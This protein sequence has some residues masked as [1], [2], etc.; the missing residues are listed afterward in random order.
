MVAADI[1]LKVGMDVEKPEVYPVPKYPGRNDNLVFHKL[2]RSEAVIFIMTDPSVLLDEDTLR[3]TE[4]AI[5]S[6]KTLYAIV[7]EGVSFHH[8]SAPNVK[9]IT[10]RP[11]DMRDLINK[12]YGEIS[13]IRQRREN[14]NLVLV[15]TMI[16]IIL[17][18]LITLY[19]I[20]QE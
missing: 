2:G 10:Y 9:V 13:R 8:S 18:A 1:A 19:A 11:R 15:L 17:M 7:P 20:S 16:V 14:E 6:G 12:I 4:F 3:E 5:S